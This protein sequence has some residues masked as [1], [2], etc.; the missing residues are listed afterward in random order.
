MLQK[1]LYSVFTRVLQE[2]SC[3]G[4]LRSYSGKSAGTKAGDAQ[5]LRTALLDLMVEGLGAWTDWKALE[6]EVQA[7]RLNQHWNGTIVVFLLYF[8]HKIQDLRELCP[9]DQ[10][11]IWYQDNWCVEALD[12]AHLEH[13]VWRIMSRALLLCRRT[14]LKLVGADKVTALDDF[15][16]HWTSL[17]NHAIKLDNTAKVN[18]K[19]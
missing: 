2:S 18:K 10:A 14:W 5:L 13:A 1:Y 12:T 15:D 9:D 17:K 7:L 11:A 16:S 19:S 6:S 8:K 4:L 3:A